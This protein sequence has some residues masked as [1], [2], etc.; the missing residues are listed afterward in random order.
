MSGHLPSGHLPPGHPLTGGQPNFVRRLAVSW[1]GA[2]PYIYIWGLLHPDEI[3]PVAKFTLRPTLAFSYIASVTA[4]R[5]SSGVSQ[6]LRR[7][8][9]NGITELS[10]RA[11][12]I[13]GWT[14]ITLAIGPH[15]SFCLVCRMLTV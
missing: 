9:R 6:T 3:F 1:A 8:T 15:S 10:Q 13:F 12:P 14:A 5:S 11:P 2:L 7:G 4:R